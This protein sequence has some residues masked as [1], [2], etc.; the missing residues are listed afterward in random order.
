MATWRRNRL[1]SKEHK[2]RAL[3]ATLVSFFARTG[4]SSCGPRQELAPPRRES[5]SPA[6]SVSGGVFAGAAPLAV[7]CCGP[8]VDPR[9]RGR[10]TRH[11]VGTES[12]AREFVQVGPCRRTHIQQLQPAAAA[13]HLCLALQDWAVIRLGGA[14]RLSSMLPFLFF[15][16]LLSIPS[17]DFLVSRTKPSTLHFPF[18]PRRTSHFLSITTLTPCLPLS[19]SPPP[20]I[21]LTSP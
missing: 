7:L 15:F 18:F 5:S 1:D 3:L 10:P 16:L 20:H 17:S 12:K 19:T 6:V 11:G 2:I 14:R 21:H 8:F 4:Q 9:R 13:G